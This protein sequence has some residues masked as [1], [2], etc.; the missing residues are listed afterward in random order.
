MACNYTTISLPC[1]GK[2]VPTVEQPTLNTNLKYTS[3]SC[4]KTLSTVSREKVPNIV[5]KFGNFGGKFVAEVLITP[6]AELEYE[7][8]SVLLDDEFKVG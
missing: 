2:V 3:K 6:L 4:T 7:F 5:G 1:V 8:N